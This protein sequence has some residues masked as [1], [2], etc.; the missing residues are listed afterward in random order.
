MS[1]LNEGIDGE[2]KPLLRLPD[3]SIASDYL[4]VTAALGF[5]PLEGEGKV[6]GLAAYGKYNANLV[7]KLEEILSDKTLIHKGSFNLNCG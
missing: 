6:T 4:L 7:D 1:A 3:I 2:I 5:K